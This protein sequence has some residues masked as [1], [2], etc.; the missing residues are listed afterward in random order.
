[1]ADVKFRIIACRRSSGERASEF[2]R[3]S[4]R[5][6]SE[7]ETVERWTRSEA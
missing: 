4:I 5:D 1:M 7:P 6:R 3:A 2:P